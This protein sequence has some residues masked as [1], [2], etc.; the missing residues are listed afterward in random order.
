MAIQPPKS[1]RKRAVEPRRDR[2]PQPTPSTRRVPVPASR[3]ARSQPPATTSWLGKLGAMVL[4]LLTGSGIAGCGW[5]AAQL[6]VKPQGVAWVTQWL[7]G[8]SPPT[9]RE[10]RP[11]S[12]AQIQQELHQAGQQPGEWLKLG[13]NVSGWDGKTP[14]TDWLVPVREKQAM[15]LSHCDR[16]VALRLYQQATDQPQAPTPTYYL[17]DQLAIAGLE[18]S[19]VIAPLVDA[20]ADNQGS[21]RALPLTELHPFE[22]APSDGVWLNLRGSRHQGNEAIAYG[23]VLYYHP[24]H[25]HLSIKTQWT[26][27][28]GELPLWQEVTGKGSPELV[29]NHTIGMEPLFEI[30]QVKPLNFA[31]SPVQLE[32]IALTEMALDD[33]AY[34]SGLMLARNRLWTTSLSWLQGVKQRQGQQWNATAQ[35]Q[36]DVVRW[37]AQAT[38]TQ[39]DGSW[40]APSQQVLAN[41]VDGRW[42]R[43][44][45]IFQRSLAAS[46][47][48]AVLLEGDQG[49]IEKRVQAAL[50][51]KPTSLAVKTWGALLVAAQQSPKAAIAWLQKQPQTTARDRAQIH[52][53]LQRLDPNF[54]ETAVVSFAPGRLI[55]DG[56]AI[57]QIQPQDW[58]TLS[59]AAPLKLAAGDR[60]YRI[61]VDRLWLGDR[62]QTGT[63]GLSATEAGDSLWPKLGLSIDSTVQLTAWDTHGDQKT[64]IAQV[65]GVRV[66][67]NQLE[68]L[69]SGPGATSE[70]K[71]PTSWLATTETAVQWLAPTAIS[72][73]EWMGQNPAWGDR[74]LPQL[75]QELRRLYPVAFSPQMAWATLDQAGLGDWQIQPIHLTG[76]TQ[77]DLILTLN[78]AAV[79]PV[80]QA[81]AGKKVTLPNSGPRTFIFSG[82]GQLLYSDGATTTAQVYRAIADLGEKTPRLV[83]SAG[84][85]SRLLQWSSQ[86][87]KFE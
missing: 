68:L 81:I 75:L 52:Q 10:D 44:T 7:P 79:A 80:A 77:P 38:K 47:E 58:R 42:E 32:A 26:S 65:R 71:L 74:A 22:Q 18:E 60:W 27:P 48:T 30:Y 36:L 76:Q 6:I 84:G 70:G 62:W 16:I 82:T 67:A 8:W 73:R 12:Q 19:F 46:Q 56:A 39:A 4:I 40:A 51:V 25:L 53:L 23:Q 85:R 66:G 3:R 78:P 33:S 37:H 24:R 17:V 54:V 34:R 9:A 57:A 11:Q 43:A 14:T 41:L 55:G 59:S 69:V 83:V 64:A 15:C 5:V 86:D 50:R 20:E 63:A 29:I 87:Q 72:L 31:P 35:A 13:N 1:V 49:R 21:S 28:T 2:P 45:T 61:Q